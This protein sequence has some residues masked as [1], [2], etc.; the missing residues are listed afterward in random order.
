MA[1]APC[2]RSS[3]KDANERREGAWIEQA[4]VDRARA[5]VG[6]APPPTPVAVGRVPKADPPF[7][8][9][10]LAF[11]VEDG[12]EEARVR[13]Q[14]RPAAR[15]ARAHIAVVRVMDSSRSGCESEQIHPDKSGCNW[16][17]RGVAGRRDG[18][19]FSEILQGPSFLGRTDPWGSN[20]LERI[21]GHQLEPVE[22][23]FCNTK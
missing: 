9:G 22:E 1:S 19:F 10:A 12:G 18:S 13:R 17:R 8:R 3:T 16:T 6:M 2:P 7:P 11:D 14:E 23:S 21:V 20:T 15:A 4:H 5:K